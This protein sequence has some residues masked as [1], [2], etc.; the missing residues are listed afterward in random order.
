MSVEVTKGTTTRRARRRRMS[1][2]E[3][4]ADASAP[5]VVL[6]RAGRSMTGPSRSPPSADPDRA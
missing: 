4:A 6:T 5:T 1:C 2:V 3:V